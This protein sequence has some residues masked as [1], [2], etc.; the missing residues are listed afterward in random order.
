MNEYEED[1]DDID[2]QNYKGIFYEDDPTSKYQDPETGA[3]FDYTDVCKRLFK[4]QRSRE[5]A[6]KNSEINS[7]LTAKEKMSLLFSKNCQGKTNKY[8]G[9][10]KTMKPQNA[11]VETEIY[12]DGASDSQEDSDG[13]ENVDESNFDS[14]FLDENLK[15]E[16]IYPPEINY[17]RRNYDNEVPNPLFLHK[18]H[19]TEEDEGNIQLMDNDFE[20]NNMCN[21][22][23]DK[24][25][26][27]EALNSKNGANY[28]K[29]PKKVHGD[30]ISR[31]V[32]SI[33]KKP[34]P[35]KL[36][37]KNNPIN[38]HSMMAMKSFKRSYSKEKGNDRE[39]SFSKDNGNVLSKIGPFKT[40]ETQSKIKYKNIDSSNVSCNYSMSHQKSSGSRCK[41]PAQHTYDMKDK[42]KISKNKSKEYSNYISSEVTHKV[43]SRTSGINKSIKK[44][45]KTKRCISAI[46]IG[47]SSRKKS[48]IS[49]NLKL[50]KTKP[51]NPY[52]YRNLS[53]YN[54]Q[55]KEKKRVIASKKLIK[56]DSL[57]KNRTRNDQRA[58]FNT[59]EAPSYIKHNESYKKNKST[60]RTRTTSCTYQSK[61]LKAASELP[62]SKDKGS[63][64]KSHINP[65]KSKRKLTK[66]DLSMHV[67]SDK[68]GSKQI[69]L[70]R[71]KY[72][73]KGASKKI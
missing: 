72:S 34:K 6:E 49:G 35:S 42:K 40:L 70:T 50:E 31:Y 62:K 33:S 23:E 21:F 66:A 46:K 67:A 7:K 61:C 43:A 27:A 54:N 8:S 20:L 24:I 45:S 57:I 73:I 41:I 2:F 3:H 5:S 56:K 52:K 13:K 1:L 28:G 22:N 26:L 19:Q 38:L 68:I 36:K 47:N 37:S 71:R 16:E 55:Y 29:R 65:V 15:D 59:N 63:I 17:H 48:T 9:Q 10:R 58:V 39:S 60:D 64:H 4:I 11:R 69:K 53:F 18:I 30:N 44:S 12:D 51:K 14:N 25:N 32:K